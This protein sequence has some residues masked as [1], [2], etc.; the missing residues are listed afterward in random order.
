MLLSLF[1]A[2]T[3]A[4]APQYNVFMGMPSEL[5]RQVKGQIQTMREGQAQDW[6]PTVQA[7]A[8]VGTDTLV[9]WRWP[10]PFNAGI[11]LQVYGPDGRFKA[12]LEDSHIPSVRATVCQNRYVVG[13]GNTLRVWDAARDYKL[14]AKKT[15]PQTDQF[16]TLGCDQNLL[17]KDDDTRLWRFLVPSLRPVD[18]RLG[19]S[20]TA[21]ASLNVSRGNQLDAAHLV[22][23]NLI[24]P[25]GDALIV[26]VRRAEYDPKGPRSV[27]VQVYDSD[28]LFKQWLADSAIKRPLVLCGK[29]LVGGDN[30][31]RVWDTA[32]K[33]R[34]IS[35]K[36]VGDAALGELRCQKNTLTFTHSSLKLTV[37]TLKLAH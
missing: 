30:T 12:R 34:L 25:M 36:A 18:V 2:L 20:A 24:T 1:V 16:A 27:G 3:T 11:G 6:T 23:Q 15:Y 32:A 9:M 22:T 37:P 10:M 29:Y 14:I 26:W 13:G 7:T 28:G 19:Q 4:Q 31:L 8:P 17:T 5:A 33:Y 21:I 35:R